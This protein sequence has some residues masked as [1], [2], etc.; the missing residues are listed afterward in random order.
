MDRKEL[1][2]MADQTNFDDTKPVE[3]QLPDGDTAALITWAFV[4]K[5]LN[6]R[7]T[8]MLNDLTLINGALSSI[9]ARVDEWLEEQQG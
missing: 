1:S 2:Q 3:F 9:N 8:P 4:M 6:E 7:M 5:E